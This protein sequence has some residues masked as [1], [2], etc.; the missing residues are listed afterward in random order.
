MAGISDQ[1]EKIDNL[2]VR[3][4][5]ILLAAGLLLIVMVWFN[6][7]H[8]PLV[9]EKEAIQ[10]DIEQKLGEIDTLALQLNVLKSKKAVDPNAAN[11]KR[12]EETLAGI[13]HTR[14]RILE[15]TSNLVAPEKMPE[16]LRSVLARVDGLQLVSLSGLGKTPLIEQTSDEKTDEEAAVAVSDSEQ[17]PYDSAYKHGMKIVFEGDFFTTLDYIRKLESLDWRFFWDSIEFQVDEY[18]RSTSSVTLYTLS[19]EENWIGI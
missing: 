15:A 1:L 18:P 11:R 16:L 7:F 13:E 12:R 5:A 10:T 2:S 4:R 8:E 14:N 6:F 19:L 9:Q 17:E 3:E